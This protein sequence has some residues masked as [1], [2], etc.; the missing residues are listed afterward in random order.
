MRTAP[1]PLNALTPAPAPA[2]CAAAAAAAQVGQRYGLPLLSPVDDAGVFTS[3]AGPFAGLAVQGEGNAAV[4]EALAGAGVLLKEEKYAH[5]YPYDWRTKK[6]T[7]F[8]AT[9]QVLRGGW[10]PARGGARGRGRGLW[11][12][13]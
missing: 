7:I 10:V 4:I 5:K 9:S 1:H 12:V 11:R 3:E 8:R 13:D 2:P 6:P